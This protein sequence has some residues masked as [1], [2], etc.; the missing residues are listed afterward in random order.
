MARI[1]QLITGRTDYDKRCLPAETIK[2]QRLAATMALQIL[3]EY[4]QWKRNS[5]WQLYANLRGVMLADEVGGGKTFETWAIL[6]KQI[7]QLKARERLR[8]L[9]IVNPAIRSKWEWEEHADF[10]AFLNSRPKSETGKFIRQTKLPSA[11]QLKLFK[12]FGRQLLIR[13][14]KQWIDMDKPRTGVWLSSFQSLPV[15]VGSGEASAF[16]HGKRVR[17]FPNNFFDWIIVDE[18]HAVKSGSK[19]VDEMLQLNNYAIRKIYAAINASASSKIILLTA[20]PF[21]NNKNELK[22]LLRLLEEDAG[23]A[24]SF[25]HAI[26]KGIDA[27][28]KIFADL[29][30]NFL[31]A[32]IADL[33]YALTH[34]VNKLLSDHTIKR[35]E[36]L[37]VNGSRNGL[38]DCLRDLM[39]RNS[40]HALPVTPV[41]AVL[42]EKEKLQYLLFREQVKEKDKEKSMFSI[43]LS[44]LVSSAAAYYGSFINKKNYTVIEQLFGDNLVA[45]CKSEKLLQL[46]QAIPLRHEK[47][48]ITVFVT[49]MKTVSALK[50]ILTRNGYPVYS[51][52]GYDKVSERKNIL[53]AVT[54]ANR[55]TDKKMVLLAS[56]VGNEGLDFDAFCN[57][58]V[59]YD[60]NYNPAVIDQRNGRVYR[61]DNVTTKEAKVQARDIQVYQ[62]FLDESYDQRILF[63]EEEKRKLKNFYMGD[64]SIQKIFEKALE[65]TDLREKEKFIRQME[66]I[67][68][69]LTPYRKH[70][71]PKYLRELG[72]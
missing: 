44:Q 59:H 70:L 66:S 9:I 60:N 10:D 46:L 48:V 35:P 54:T 53:Q 11:Q 43:K 50:E 30:E 31:E 45:R 6:A 64:S 7:L 65:K 37:Q 61:G 3:H 42:S 1:E 13:S 58:V 29:K 69:D 18:A 2:A 32:G 39:I 34:D 41:K 24:N 49:W 47:N 26:G 20:T 15:T 33:R 25:T 57:R 36:S 51:L 72:K 71:L 28:E 8:I 27:V 17:V 21:Q 5:A 12:F 67:K 62:L 22:H 55:Q 4:P 52:T 68:I 16:R 38:N 40:K 56:R 14:K 19:D 63:I 23:K